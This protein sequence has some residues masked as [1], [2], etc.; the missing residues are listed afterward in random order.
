ME[1]AAIPGTWLQSADRKT[2]SIPVL[3]GCHNAGDGDGG[4]SGESGKAAKG[5]RFLAPE[6]AFC[7]A[8]G[9]PSH[10]MAQVWGSELACECRRLGPALEESSRGKWKG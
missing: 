1:K 10:A 5:N 9:R 2:C 3:H 6:K 7:V 8:Q 4:P